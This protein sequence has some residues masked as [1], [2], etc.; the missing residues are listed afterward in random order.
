MKGLVKSD[1]ER[2]PSA[3]NGAGKKGDMF[4]SFSLAIL[5]EAY[6][7]IDRAFV[8]ELPLELALVK[9]LEQNEKIV[10]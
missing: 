6:S 9:I 5:L 2:K 10:K 7:E 4:N 1:P 8:S 3:S